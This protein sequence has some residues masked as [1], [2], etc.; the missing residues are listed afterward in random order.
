MDRVC[1]FCFFD[2]IDNFKERFNQVNAA[3]E[4]PDIIEKTEL[5][6]QVAKLK[7]LKQN[8]L[9]ENEKENPDIAED[10]Y[11]IKSLDKNR[12]NLLLN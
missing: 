8:Y 7:L 1:L 11:Q 6:T 5:D 2:S 3:T 4:N 9:S 12:I 10:N